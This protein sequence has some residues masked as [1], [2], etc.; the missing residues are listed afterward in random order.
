MSTARKA[1]S[2]EETDSLAHVVEPRDQQSCRSMSRTCCRPERLKTRATPAPRRSGK[3]LRHGEGLR[4]ACGNRTGASAWPRGTSVQIPGCQRQTH[5]P[6]HHWS[7]FRHAIPRARACLK[8]S[9]MPSAPQN[10]K[11]S[12]TPTTDQAASGQWC[13][14]SSHWVMRLSRNLPCSSCLPQSVLSTCQRIG[15]SRRLSIQGG[16]QFRIMRVA[17]APSEGTPAT[18]PT[19]TLRRLAQGRLRDGPGPGDSAD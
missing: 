6:P 4:Y 7:I 5:P 16:S 2:V 9:P 10:A 19:R 17:G 18:N 1:A 14:T 15:C 12:K 13:L 3:P 8:P 11:P